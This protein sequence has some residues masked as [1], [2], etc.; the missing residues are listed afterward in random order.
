MQKIIYI[1][2]AIFFILVFNL[3]ISTAVNA[4]SQSLFISEFMPDPTGSDSAYEWIELYNAGGTEINTA[5][6][7]IN[8]ISIPEFFLAP[9]KFLIL[10]RDKTSLIELFPGITAVEVSFSLSNSGGEIILS[11]ESYTDKI[12]Y[13]KALENKSFERLGEL[14]DG[15]SINTNGNTI[16]QI[17]SNYL[18]SCWSNPESYPVSEPASSPIYTPPVS[19]PISFFQ[20]IIGEKEIFI[21]LISE[22]YPSPITQNGEM[23][24]IEIYNPYN[25]EIDFSGYYISDK[26]Y[27]EEKSKN[28][29]LFTD[30][31]IEENSYFIIESPPFSLNNSGDELYLYSPNGT[32]IDTVFYNSITNGSSAIRDEN[33][34]YNGEK[35]EL[36]KSG[37]PSKGFSNS[38]IIVTDNEKKIDAKTEVKTDVNETTGAT[39]GYKTDYPVIKP[40]VYWGNFVLYKTKINVGALV[41]LVST[42]IYSI[43][44]LLKRYKKP[45]EKYF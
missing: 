39:L 26:S 22:V 15:V 10:A 17:N 21:L 37:A 9:K 27:K 44:L 42:T 31:L 35:I 14:C 36:N 29:Y 20:E 24:W 1:L 19:A 41:L 23:E 13:P 7:K 45:N 3:K 18:D 32:V 4:D 6:Y 40:L 33:I 43:I 5:G 25:K 8:N 30:T 28:R 11:K 16:G 12:T 2:S 34:L 38:Q